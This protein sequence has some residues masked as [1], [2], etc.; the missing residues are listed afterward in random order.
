M[1]LGS[2]FALTAVTGLSMM[3][4]PGAAAAQVTTN[5]KEVFTWSGEVP[6]GR[7]IRI[8]NMNGPVNVVAATGRSVE[9]T[10]V[11]RWRRGSPEIVRFDVQRLAERGG[12]PSV[13]VCALWGSSTCSERGYQSR[14]SNRTNENDVSIEFTVRVPRGVRVAAA[15]V[16][17][18]VKIADAAAE[19]EASTVNGDV[20]IAASGGP[21]RGSTTNGNV[22]A[23]AD[24]LG[25]GVAGGGGAGAV[26][27]AVKLE[28]VNGRV[29]LT[30]PQSV[31][32]NLDLRT[33]NGTIRTD[34]PITV[35]GRLDPKRITS[36]LGRGGGMVS[37]STVNGS[38]ELRSAGR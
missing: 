6:A 3:A 18:N 9:I 11:A 32:A 1:R 2:M 14:G 31:D 19:V 20:D 23:R 8:R 4:S 26:P 7:W 21:I 13:L 22:T 5:T 37:L 35:S 29:A 38:V 15:T 17:G 27:V 30:L 25:S 24:V 28:T 16:N 34:Y 10:A 33:V 12:E 36:Q